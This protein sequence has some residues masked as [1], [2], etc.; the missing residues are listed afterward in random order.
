MPSRQRSQVPHP[1][2]TSTPTRAPIAKRS[3]FETATSPANSWPGTCGNLVAG[4]FPES[5]FASVAQTIDARTRTR[6]SRGPGRGVE[7]SRT[8]NS[9]GAPKTTASI[10]PGISAERVDSPTALFTSVAGPE[11]DRWIRAGPEERPRQGDVEDLLR[12]LRDPVL[13]EY[14]PVAEGM[15]SQPHR[16]DRHRR[17]PLKAVV[18]VHVRE[19]L[20]GIGDDRDHLRGFEIVDAAARTVRPQDR[21]PVGRKLLRLL[22]ELLQLTLDRRALHP[23]EARGLAVRGRRRPARRLEHLVHVGIVHHAWP[24]RADRAPRPHEGTYRPSNIDAHG[25]TIT[26][27]APSICSLNVRSASANSDSLKWCVMSFAAGMRPSAM[28]GI[29]SSIVLR[30]ARTPYRSISSRTTFWKSTDDGSLGIPVNATRPPL[31]TIPID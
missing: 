21:V 3:S 16:V 30:F 7:T 15:R 26:F 28:S 14:A 27:S 29:T 6:T 17:G 11:S 4:N 10:D 13:H 22:R 19:A 20:R 9:F 31:R 18:G 2:C 5:I 12:L 1:T 8:A 23:D 24:E 25:C